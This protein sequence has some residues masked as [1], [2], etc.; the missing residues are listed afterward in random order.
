MPW[1]LAQQKQPVSNRRARL[2]LNLHGLGGMAN[3]SHRSMCGGI[4]TGKEREEGMTLFTAADCAAAA[5]THV[6]EG[7]ACAGIFAEC[8]IGA[9]PKRPESSA[10]KPLR[11]LITDEPYGIFFKR[12]RAGSICRNRLAGNRSYP[13]IDEG[14]DQEAQPLGLGNAVIVEKGNNRGFADREPEIPRPG[15]GRVSAQRGNGRHT[16]LRHTLSRGH[17][18]NYR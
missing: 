12:T 6:K 13:G 17:L 4:T 10:L 11:I 7:W 3:D 16:L 9:D 15:S 1:K 5:K 14:L 18:G 2:L 8:H